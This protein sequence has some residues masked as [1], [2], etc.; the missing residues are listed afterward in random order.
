MLPWSVLRIATMASRW[1][2]PAEDVDSSKRDSSPKTTATRARSSTRAFEAEERT[3]TMDEKAKTYERPSYAVRD[4]EQRV[5]A[6]RGKHLT[7]SV[8]HIEWAATHAMRTDL[9]A[10]RGHVDGMLG[11]SEFWAREGLRAV[12][13]AWEHE[14]ALAKFKAALSDAAYVRCG[15]DFAPKGLFVY[16]RTPGS[17][18]GVT[19]SASI[20]RCPEAEALMEAARSCRVS[21]TEG[22]NKSGAGL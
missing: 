18:S 3:T 14:V 7:D 9:D 19:L 20:D 15:R 1:A 8:D 6:I 5:A 12:T 4:M 11:S 17:P 2:T 16:R 13:R 21:P 10:L 22:L